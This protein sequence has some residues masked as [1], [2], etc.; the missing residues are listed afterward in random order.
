[1]EPDTTVALAFAFSRRF[2]TAVDRNRAKRRLRAAFVDAGGD[3]CSGA[4]LMTGRR[5]LLDRPYEALVDDVRQCV[6]HL[7]TVVDLDTTSD[8]D[9]VKVER[10]RSSR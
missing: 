4:I 3:R 5:E 2:G 1:M 7:E 10:T 6:A 8:L 9:T